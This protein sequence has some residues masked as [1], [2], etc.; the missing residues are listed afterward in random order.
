M[1]KIL[2]LVLVCLYIPSYLC[3]A[4]PNNLEN[5][6]VKT[7]TSDNQKDDSNQVIE[8]EQGTERVEKETQVSKY[9]NIY[10]SLSDIEVDINYENKSNAVKEASVTYYVKDHTGDIVWKSEPHK[11]VVKKGETV[12]DTIKPV[13]SRYD[14]YTISI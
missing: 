11:I 6:E 10:T 7:Q 2:A 3:F 8:K 14:I 9:G 4:Y 1:K 12:S 5:T 13:V